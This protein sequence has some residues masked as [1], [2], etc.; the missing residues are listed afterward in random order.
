MAEAYFLARA[1]TAQR[2]GRLL[3]CA[4]VAT[5]SMLRRRGA[6]QR[7]PAL[8]VATPALAF[9]PTLALPPLSF[10]LSTAYLPQPSDPAVHE[11]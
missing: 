1:S 9:T 8:G 2:G 6:A 11:P 5:L 7:L 4:R 10:I 3:G